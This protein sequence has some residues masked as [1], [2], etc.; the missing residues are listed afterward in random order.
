MATTMTMNTIT[1]TMTMNAITEQPPLHDL[2]RSCF[3]CGMANPDGL[4]LTFSMNPEGVAISI[5]Q[6]SHLFQSYSDRV[7]GGVIATLLDSAMVHGLFAH[8]VAGVTAELTIRYLRPVLVNAPI[9]IAGWVESQQRNLSLC[10]AEIRQSDM[11]MVK[12]TAK[13]LA[14]PGHNKKKACMLTINH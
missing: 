9:H 5:W 1:T 6:P 2:H 11:L 8:G 10:R 13:F 4:N 14:L 3:A 7:H 12:A